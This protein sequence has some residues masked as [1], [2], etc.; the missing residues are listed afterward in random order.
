MSRRKPV[1]ACAVER[2]P[3]VRPLERVVRR[4][5]DDPPRARCRPRSCGVP[6]RPPA[7]PVLAQADLAGDHVRRPGRSHR[8]AGMPRGRRARAGRRARPAATR[9][10]GGPRGGPRRAGPRTPSMSSS[11]RTA[12]R[13][14][15]STSSKDPPAR[16][17]SSIASQ[18]SATASGWLRPR[19]AARWRRASSAALKMSSRS[20]SQGVRRIAAMVSAGGRHVTGIRRHPED[21]PPGGPAPGESGSALGRSAGPG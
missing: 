4:D 18:M 2:E 10:P 5:A 8:G 21:P 15:A 7:R 9:R 11:S 1:A 14:A 3:R 6:A 19:P 16:A 20:S 12:V 17:T 13:P